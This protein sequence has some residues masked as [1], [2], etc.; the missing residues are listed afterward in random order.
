ML[1]FVFVVI[2][3]GVLMVAC[4]LV[5][6]IE[7]RS[8]LILT[9]LYGATWALYAWH[10]VAVIVAQCLMSMILGLATFGV[11]FLTRRH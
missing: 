1:P 3:T 10:P 9:L 8:K 7:F 2:L 6:D 5:A 4:W 11:E